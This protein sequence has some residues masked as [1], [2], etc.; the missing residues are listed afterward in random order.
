MKKLISKKDT[1]FVLTA[2]IVILIDQITKYFGST[3]GLGKTIPIIPNIFHFTYQVNPG[4]S[5]SMFQGFFWLT[6]I[7][8]LIVIGAILYYYNQMPKKLIIPIALILGGTIGNLIDRIAFDG[9]VRDFIDFQ[10]WPVFNIA[11]SALVIG[12]AILIYYFFK[13][14]YLDKKKPVSKPIS[15]TKSIKTKSI[16]KKSKK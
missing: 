2:I 10:V 8:S 5:F 6:F 4:S 11:D 1:I 9:I 7:A 15:N 16:K 12:A 14:E 13:K 3:I